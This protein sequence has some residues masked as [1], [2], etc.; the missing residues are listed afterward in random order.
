MQASCGKPVQLPVNKTS[1]QPITWQQLL[2]RLSDVIV[3]G[4][5]AALSVLETAD[6]LGFPR[7]IISKVYRE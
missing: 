6:V 4:R 5:Q 2:H 3:G 1:N 7:T